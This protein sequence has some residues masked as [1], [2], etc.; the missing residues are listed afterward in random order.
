[1]GTAKFQLVL[2]RFRLLG[3]LMKLLPKGPNKNLIEEG[4]LYAGAPS[5]F[6]TCP[7]QSVNFKQLFSL[8]LHSIC[9]DL[10]DHVRGIEI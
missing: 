9:S 6:T 7:C 8:Y 5:H 2:S 10:G 1:M 3:E 4:V